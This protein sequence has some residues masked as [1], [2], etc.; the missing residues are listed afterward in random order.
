MVVLPKEKNGSYITIFNMEGQE[1]LRQKITQPNTT[2]D[3]SGWKS[4]VYL[5]KVVGEKRVQVGKFVK[6]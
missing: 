5:V 6:Q 4:G 3:V 1:L 2:I